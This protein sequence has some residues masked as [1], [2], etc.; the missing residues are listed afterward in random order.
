MQPLSIHS[1]IYRNTM[2]NGADALTELKTLADLIKSNVD[3][4]ETDSQICV[5]LLP[6]PTDNVQPTKRSRTSMFRLHCVWPWRLEAHVAEFLR[7]AG[8][9]GAHVEDIARPLNIDPYKLARILR[10]LATNHFFVEVA[11]DVFANN[12]ISSFLDSGKSVETLV[13]QPPRGRNV[14]VLGMAP[15]H[16]FRW[17]GNAAMNGSRTL[18]APNAI[19]GGFGWKNLKEG[20]LVIDVGGG[21]RAVVIAEGEKFWE[22]ATPEYLKSGKVKFQP[23]NFMNEDQ[24]VK[25]ADVFVRGILHDWADQYCV[26]ILR[27]L[28]AAAPNTRLLVVDQLVSYACKDEDAND[29]PGVAPPAPLLPNW[30]EHVVHG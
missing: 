26:K 10:L 8:S 18:L 6:F 27:S 14:Q 19:V 11:P 21:D 30:G 2:S 4:I 15:R 3:R 20:A 23:F 22:T 24:P 1:A 16:H 7:D 17:F 12:R 13:A 25:H 5:S 9:K 28:R 29:I